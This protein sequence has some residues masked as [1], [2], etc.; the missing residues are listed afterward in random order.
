LTKTIFL[1]GLH[2][3]ILCPWK[4]VHLFFSFGGRGFF[5]L[6]FMLEGARQI[7]RYQNVSPPTAFVWSI[8]KRNHLQCSTFGDPLQNLP[9]FTYQLTL[10]VEQNRWKCAT[11]GVYFTVYSMSWNQKSCFTFRDL[12]RSLQGHNYEHRLYLLNG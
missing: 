12:S 7:G 1:R 3:V 8:W 11:S 10:C 2:S 6:H 4:T 9:T 5:S